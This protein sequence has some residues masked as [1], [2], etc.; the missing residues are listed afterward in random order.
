MIVPLG[1]YLDNHKKF[2]DDLEHC[3]KVFAMNYFLKDENGKYITGMLDKLSWTMWAEGRFRGDYDAIKTPV[4]YI[5]KYED[6]KELFKVYLEKDYT[7]KDY[8]TQFSIR[9]THL[10]EKLD[11]I[12]K[13]YKLESYVPDFFWN[14]LNQQRSDLKDLK[15]KFSKDV[16]SP[17]DF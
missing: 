10:L 1:K 16:I 2:G 11:R 4:G 8:I 5:P 14:M 3:P 6:L 15:V 13:W 17:Q 7:E 12:E 9:T